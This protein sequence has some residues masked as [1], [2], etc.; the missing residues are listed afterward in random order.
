MENLKICRGRLPLFLLVSIT[1]V[2]TLFGSDKSVVKDALVTASSWSMSKKVLVGGGL[3]VA[4]YAGSG[5]VKERNEQAY[6]FLATACL[7]PAAP[8]AWDILSMDYIGLGSTQE[9]LRASV[10]AN[11]EN[12]GQPD[13][14]KKTLK[15]GEERLRTTVQKEHI[16]NAAVNF[17][18][19]GAAGL[20]LRTVVGISQET[21][22]GAAKQSVIGLGVMYCAGKALGFSTQAADPVE[23]K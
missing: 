6:N 1:C 9:H 4:G 15:G 21:F 18:L 16:R 19:A 5:I 13:Y 2:S 20:A 12:S 23:E 17:M 10:S 14:V 8:A 7:I 3:V 22:W 11:K